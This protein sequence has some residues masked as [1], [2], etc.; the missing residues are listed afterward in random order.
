MANYVE[1]QLKKD[2]EALAEAVPAVAV[3]GPR[4]AGKTTFLKHEQAGKNTS[5]AVFDDPDAR[6]L[7]ETDVKKFEAQYVEG[8][9]RTVLD[10]VQYCKNA[11]QNIKYLAD[12]G[13]KLWITA[14]SETLL[15]A[16]VLSHL[17]GRVS[18]LRLYPF[19]L[20]EFLDAK[21][22][23]EST[24]EMLSR[25]VWEHAT[26]GG[27][28][29]VCLEQGIE[30]KKTMLRD[31][32]ETMILKDMAQVFSIQETTALQLFSKHAAAS[33]G[34]LFSSESASRD[35]RLS[36]QTIRKYSDAME[37]SYLIR[38]A[39]PFFSNKSKELV[40]QPKL[41]FVDCGL[42]NAIANSFAPELDGRIFENYVYS[43]LLKAGHSPK[44]WRTKAGAEVDFVVEQ[45]NAPFP[46]EAKLTA[47]PGR[48]SRSL[49]SFINAYKPKAAAVVSYKPVAAQQKFGGC[50]ITYCDPLSMHAAINARAGQ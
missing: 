35:L 45:G 7:F 44:Y 38:F 5:Y 26:Y 30:T 25:A 29:R 10:E 17:V 40:K 14:S 15:A 13:H 1:R 39:P 28:P 20:P 41:F 48:I 16:S 3:V 33:A 31:L 21:A 11:G 50:T 2:F 24:P 8:F 23:K 37:K 19:S 6:T 18:I 34:T 43:E 47:E 32:A 12:K 49:R 9:E 27:Y 22:Q 42:R 36:Y 4:Q 46:V